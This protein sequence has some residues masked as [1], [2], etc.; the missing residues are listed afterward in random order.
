MPA[1]GVVDQR[2]A[3][4]LYLSDREG[5]DPSLVARSEAMRSTFGPSQTITSLGSKDV[6]APGLGGR[7]EMKTPDGFRHRT[8]DGLTDTAAVVCWR[9][10]MSR[11]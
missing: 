5:S 10:C 2:T 6:P 11:C 4:D 8:T 1:Q 9:A 3:A 7:L